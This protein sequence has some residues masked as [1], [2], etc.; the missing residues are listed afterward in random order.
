MHAWVEA[1]VWAILKRW[2]VMPAYPYQAGFSR[3]S[4]AFCIFGNADQFA[5][6]KWM[7]ANR[8]AKLVRYEKNFG[9][10]LKRARGLDELSS[11]GTV[12]QAARSRPDLVAAC[13][14]DGALQTVLTED[15]THPAGAFGTGGGPV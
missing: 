5:T 2:R 6:L 14:S 12:Y 15:W 11:E 7:D 4:C 13:L 9:C 1:E 3:L 8:F 10:T